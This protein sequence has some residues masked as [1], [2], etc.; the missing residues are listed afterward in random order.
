MPQKKLIWKAFERAGILDSRDEKILKF[1]DFLKHTPA[2]CWIEVI[3][4]F[5]KDH[6][7]CFDAIV[8]VLVEIDDPL[9][10]SVLVKHA[11]MSQPR[12][13]ALVRKMADTVDPERHPTLIKQLAR[14]N[15][16]E[17]SRRLQ[18]R[19]LPAPLAS[20]ISK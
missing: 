10:Q 17:T 6:E 19:N 9:I 16:P 12:E 15:D 7:A 1:L 2:S 11:D 4:E 13:R 8:P 14:F 3:P 5:R 18:R 20:L